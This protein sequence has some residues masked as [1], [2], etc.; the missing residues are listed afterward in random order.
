MRNRDLKSFDVYPEKE[1]NLIKEL[2]TWDSFYEFSDDINVW[3][4]GAEYAKLLTES[5]FNLLNEKDLGYKFDFADTVWNKC[6]DNYTKEILD[7]NSNNINEL[8]ANIENNCSS[9]TE[10]ISSI[11]FESYNSRIGRLQF[12]VRNSVINILIKRINEKV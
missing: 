10:P 1:K 5:A 4:N 9:R 12:T 8:I 3:R 11:C 2:L 6:I 7:A